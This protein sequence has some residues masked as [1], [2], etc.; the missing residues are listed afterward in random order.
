MD[1]V[2]LP[3]RIAACLGASTLV[4]TNASGGIRDDLL[5][6]DLVAIVNHLNLM[7]RNPLVG[8]VLE[9]EARF[10]DMTVP[11]DAGLRS[12][13]AKVAHERGIALAEGVYAAVLGP[14]Y[15]TASEVAMLARLGADLVGMSTV[16][17]VIVARAR[18]MRCLA[19]SMVTNRAAGLSE[20]P[21]S[22]REVLEVGARSAGRLAELVSGVVRGLGRQS[23][24]VSPENGAK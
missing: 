18:G 22:H 14:S 19:L 11:Y 23:P 16:P 8:P 21:L 15:E 9:G 5:P 12:L 4:A 2:A 13:A 17:E 10:P 20:A 7:F 24:T 6:G 3:V 1:A